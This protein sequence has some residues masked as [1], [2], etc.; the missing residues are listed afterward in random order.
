MN[1]IKEQIIEIEKKYKTKE[2]TEK[3]T[4]RYLIEHINRL[5]KHSQ[6]FLRERHRD[7][8]SDEMKE[9]LEFEFTFVKNKISEARDILNNRKDYQEVLDK[10]KFR[11]DCASSY[12]QVFLDDKPIN[13]TDFKIIQHSHND[14]KGYEAY[15]PISDLS[16]GRHQLKIKTA[17]KNEDGD[18]AIRLIP[19]YKQ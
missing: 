2:E 14:E 7:N 1:I 6:W 3:M 10:E 19:F 5:S 15:I 16:S 11:N 8:K 12:Y 9:L 18:F 13:G 17:Y 4:T